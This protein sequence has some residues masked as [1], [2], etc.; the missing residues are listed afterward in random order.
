MV[1]PVFNKEAL[2]AASFCS[3]Y[4]RWVRLPQQFQYNVPPTLAT[5][6]RADAIHTGPDGLDYFVEPLVEKL[7]LQELLNQIS[8]EH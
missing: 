5:R 3:S 6:S 2:L 1:R 8:S 7:T 4:A